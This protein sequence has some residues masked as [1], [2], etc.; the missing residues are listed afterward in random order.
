M[1]A[2]PYYAQFAESGAK[3]CVRSMFVWN[4]QQYCFCL[5]LKA[6]VFYN[7]KFCVKM[8]NMSFDPPLERYTVLYKQGI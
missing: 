1:W 6:I 8:H 3:V 5:F 4:Y 2:G 7:S